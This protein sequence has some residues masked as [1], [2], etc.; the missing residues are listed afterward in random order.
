MRGP[1]ARPTQTN[2]SQA[3]GP[4]TPCRPPPC[5]CGG[6]CPQ[7]LQLP[8]LRCHQQVTLALRL[9][10]LAPLLALCHAGGGGGGE[11][12][13]GTR[14]TSRQVGGWVGEAA[15][16]CRGVA[17]RCACAAAQVGSRPSSRAPYGSVGS[18]NAPVNHPPDRTHLP[19]EPRP[20]P[21]SS[22]HGEAPGPAPGR[23]RRRARLQQGAMVVDDQPP[24]NDISCSTASFPTLPCFCRSQPRAGGP[25]PRLSSRPPVSLT[26]AAATARVDTAAAAPRKVPAGGSAVPLL[27]LALARVPHA[28]P[29]APVLEGG[30][31]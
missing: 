27:T 16:P 8:P 5:T 19:A 22:P 6:G 30:G 25:R 9:L 31:R 17:A 13:G 11:G 18:P 20:R 14:Q 24:Y 23:R 26:H 21:R 1:H 2:D 7:V 3:R 28:A 4:P 29:L 10:L 15:V 12:G